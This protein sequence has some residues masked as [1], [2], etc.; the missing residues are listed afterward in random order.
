MRE[1][2]Q[3]LEGDGLA[4]KL[5]NRGWFVR[6]FIPQQIRDLYEFRAAAECLGVRLASERI[7]ER[8]VGRPLRAIEEHSRMIE[9]LA[10]RDAQA[11]EQLMSA[12]ILGPLEDLFRTGV[13]QPP[14][15]VV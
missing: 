10:R 15:C 5:P 9:L 6:E 14:F 2:V 13:S 4:V 1:A 12:H 3:R 8:I 7:T 11:A